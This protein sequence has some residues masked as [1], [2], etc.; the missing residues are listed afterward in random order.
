MAPNVQS[1]PTGV[2]HEG[3][4]EI[5]AVIQP[6]KDEKPTP[7]KIQLVWRNIII[8]VYLHAIA[9]YGFY[10]MLTSARIYTSI[11]G[12]LFCAFPRFPETKQYLSAIILYQLGGFGVT[13]GAHRLWSH[14]AYKAKWPFRLFLAFCNTLAFEVCLFRVSKRDPTACFPELSN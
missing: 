2:L 13:A 11:Y 3:D 14:R 7:R 1:A 6:S 12:E 5:I 9:L 8:F 4:E 10:L